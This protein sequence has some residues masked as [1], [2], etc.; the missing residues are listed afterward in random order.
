ME[1]TINRMKNTIKNIFTKDLYF[2]LFISTLIFIIFS[3]VIIKDLILTYDDDVLLSSLHNIKSFS[4]YISSILN[5]QILDIQPIRDLSFLADFKIKS[6]L[7]VYS[8]HFTNVLIWTLICFNARKILLI[9]SKDNFYIIGLLVIMYAL[10][11]VSANSVAWISARKHL[12]S[13]L[14]ITYATVL[15]LKNKDSLK[16]RTLIPIVFLY[17]LSCFSHPINTLW[18]L[19]L[20]Y[21][22]LPTQ[23]N[24]NK[25]ILISLTSLV[26]LVSILLNLYYYNFTYSN[27]VSSISKFSNTESLDLGDP[28][29]A[30]G[31]YFYQ[32][33]NTFSALPHSHYQGS[34]QNL[35]GLFLL[36][37][38]LFYCYKQCKKKDF[39][40]IGP[41]IY[42]FFPLA[43]VTLNMTNIFCSD[44]YLLNS[45]IGFYCALAIITESFKKNKYFITALTFYIC[46]VSLYTFNY[47]Q[48]FNNENELWIYS[49]KKE[50]TPQT[51]IVA[52]SIYIKQKRFKESYLLI[53]EIQSR[54][55][56]HPFLPQLIAENIFY[57]SDIKRSMKIEKLQELEP[58][59]PASFL[60]LSILY[61]YEEDKEKVQSVIYKI[62]DDPRKFNMEFRGNETKIAAIFFYTCN[63]FKLTQCK[64]KLEDYQN[65]SLNKSWDKEQLSNFIKKLELSKSYQII[66]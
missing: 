45:S 64:K 10:N 26:G 43:I 20:Y 47:V 40:L 18:F 30:L 4:H 55:P 3:R 12:L 7:P 60:Y 8:F 38:F 17:F 49:Q 22:I 27:N 6:I 61:G 21:L 44:T 5:G 39:R 29:L 65:E 15:V 34:W 14:F 56:H 62:F 50:P 58:K 54:W 19:W 28:L 1:A 23:S 16:I 52:S 24:K 32:C 36:F 2:L 25:W 46:V 31:R 33:L 35:A 42:F 37:A 59:T 48:I 41:V 66:L 11:P 13:T 63:Y 51:T 53:E 57:N 9:Y